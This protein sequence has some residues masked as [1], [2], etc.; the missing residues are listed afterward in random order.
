VSAPAPDWPVWQAPAAWRAIDFISDLHLQEAEPATFEAWRLFMATTTA[1]ALVVLGDLFEV[2][3]GDDLI[4]QSAFEDH[5]VAVLRDTARR[6]PVYFM[7]GNRDF[8]VGPGCLAAAGMHF[9]E[10]PTVLDAFG[11]RWLLSHGDALCLDDTDYMAFR[12]EVR[13]KAW[14]ENFLARPLGARQALARQLRDA[15]EARKKS[16]DIY[17][18]VDAGMA[19]D[20]LAGCGARTLVHG[21]THRPAEQALGDGLRRVVL[22][23]WDASASPSRLEVLRLSGEG[24]ERRPLPA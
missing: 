16:G 9:L 21:H 15:S 3:V 8:L 6:L 4:G 23:D 18:D 5:C 12:A 17:A 7:H 10:D 1:D 13:S 22:S 24:L 19:R 2:W 11:Q 14:R 20:W